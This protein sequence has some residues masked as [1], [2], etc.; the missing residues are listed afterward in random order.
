MSNKG[1]LDG[2]C[3]ICKA[4]VSKRQVKHLQ[5]C[6]QKREMG[7]KTTGRKKP[8]AKLFHLLVE[9]YGLSGDLYWMHLKVL[10][11]ARFRDL[12]SFLRDTWLECC[13]HMSVF[14]DKEGDIDMGEK[15]SDILR[16]DLKLAYEYDFGSTTE[17]TLKVIAE[18]KGSLSKRQEVEILAR[19]NAPQIK[20]SECDRLAMT[21]C[22]D[23]IWDNKGWLCDDC[24]RKHGCDEEMFLPVVNSPRTGVCAY[25]G[26]AAMY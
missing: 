12:D 4:K 19:N 13:G 1:Q 20:C 17:L 16:P 2:T 18:F 8:A 23:C 9:G 3:E 6:L 15:L 25:E 24:A 21:I 10:G 22:A 7:E 5:T 26:Q 11:S 14:S